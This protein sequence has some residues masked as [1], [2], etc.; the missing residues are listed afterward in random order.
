MMYILP[1]NLTIRCNNT[2]II[3]GVFVLQ[4]MRVWDVY[5]RN[6]N[7]LSLSKSMQCQNQNRR[8]PKIIL[9]LAYITRVRTGCLTLSADGS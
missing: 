7:K 4:N 2:F 3:F 1:S 9:G 6:K 8:L 5:C